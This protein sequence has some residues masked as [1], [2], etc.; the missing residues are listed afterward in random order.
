M[1]PIKIL[2]IFLILLSGCRTTK[3]IT[4]SSNLSSKTVDSSQSVNTQDQINVS[5]D[6]ISDLVTVT[7]KTTYY[8][9]EANK[10][11][12]DEKSDTDKEIKGAVQSIE[13]TTI[14]K[15]EVDKS[16]IE[17]NQSKQEENQTK[18]SDNSIVKTFDK[19]VKRANPNVK[20]FI[21]LILV[22]AAA[23]FWIWLKKSPSGLVVKTFFKKLFGKL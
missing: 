20:W 11:T 17:I 8:P 19:E 14:K 6:K 4:E 7:T 1:K 15:G 13:V 21:I 2:L 16:K 10:A 5:N 18:V 22:T 23:G 12:T 9:P 3:K